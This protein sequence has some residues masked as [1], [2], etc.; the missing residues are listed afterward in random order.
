[1]MQM[2]KKRADK[3]AWS[4]GM[5]LRNM[6]RTMDAKNDTDEQQKW[7]WGTVGMMPMN[8]KYAKGTRNGVEEKKCAKGMRNVYEAL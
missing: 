3:G 6:K 7:H 5:V 1:M 8:D 4:T 2:G